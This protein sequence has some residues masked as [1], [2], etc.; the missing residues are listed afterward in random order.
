MGPAAAKR[1]LL[2]QDGAVNHAAETAMLRS[3]GYDVDIVGSGSEAVGAVERRAYDLVLMDVHLP[4]TDGLEATR[5]IRQREDG[6]GRTPIVAVTAG[7]LSGDRERCLAAGMDDCISKPLRMA[8]L[9][10]LVRKWVD[11]EA[12]PCASFRAEPSE[13]V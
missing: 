3:A 6:A 1:V 10:L 5:L 13:R 12:A 8:D 4:G 9:L 2:V 11:E 7:A